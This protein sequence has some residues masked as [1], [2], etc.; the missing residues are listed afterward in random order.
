MIISEGQKHYG[1]DVGKLEQARAL[2]NQPQIQTK[3]SEIVQ[4]FDESEPKGYTLWR[5]E[6]DTDRQRKRSQY[7][8][9]KEIDHENYIGQI[10]SRSMFKPRN[11]RVGSLNDPKSKL[12]R[13]WAVIQHAVIENEH[14]TFTLQNLQDIDRKAVGNNRQLGKIGLIILREIG[15][16]R[17][18]DRVGV[19]RI[20]AI[21]L[22]DTS[23]PRTID[24]YIIE[25]L[26]DIFN[27][28]EDLS[29][30]EEPEV[31]S[32]PESKDRHDSLADGS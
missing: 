7:R 3:T 27:D 2:I 9:Y 32:Y 30:M 19:S 4:P 14:G 21:A 18:V 28:L 17:I 13:I 20:Y 1:I 12:S 26:Q 6:S 22:D 24:D 16:I 10:V 15:W 31:D 5:D 29:H 23:R 25:P 8:I 11:Y